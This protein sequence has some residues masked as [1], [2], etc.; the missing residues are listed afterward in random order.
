MTD[1]TPSVSEQNRARVRR[2]PAVAI[3][4]IGA[5]GVAALGLL[6]SRPDV[7]AVGIPLALSV[8]VAITTRAQPSP[9]VSIEARTDADAEA[10]HDVITVD[11]AAPAVELDVVQGGRARATVLVPGRSRLQARLSVRH[12]GPVPAVEIEGRVIGEDAATLGP[13]IAPASITRSVPPPSRVLR[14][15]PLPARLTGVHGAHDGSRPGQGG[16]FRDIHPFAPGD[17]LR[18]VDWRATARAAMRP[19]DLLVRRTDALSDASVVIVMD[20]ADD[21]G[22]VVAT[23]G[24]RDPER[25]GI[26]SLDVAREAARSL[27]E[28][29]AASRDRVSFH[30]LAHGGRTIRSGAGA[31]HL[32]R[33][34]AEISASGEGGDDAR[35][36]RTPPVPH[37]SIIYVLSTFFD[38]AAAEIAKTWRASGHHVVGVDVLPALD[39]TRLEPERDLTLRV[40]LAERTDMMHEL[41]TAGIDVVAWRDDPALDLGALAMVRP[42][43][44]VGR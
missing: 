5:V 44:G 8:V 26:T 35:F 38:G 17:E 42:N 19:G 43:S 23:W 3:A 32:A 41:R 37:G 4:A 39:R 24:R 16:D 40:L 22:A 25:S 15:L 31:R 14:R 30:T 27:A 29:A 2:S 21:L 11:S 33:V 18:R 9:T 13:M 7:V 36:R 28:A 20:T 34:V 1:N 12:S 6:F 10:L